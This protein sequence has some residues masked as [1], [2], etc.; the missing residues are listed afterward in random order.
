MRSIQNVFTPNIYKKGNITIHKG[1]ISHVFNGFHNTYKKGNITNTQGITV[2]VLM[3]YIILR[4][5]LVL[6][7]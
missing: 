5:R 2:I 6:E 3:V 1:T 7:C 4:V